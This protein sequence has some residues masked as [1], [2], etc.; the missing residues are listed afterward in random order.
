M[1]AKYGYIGRMLF[2]NLSD[3]T[4]RTEDLSE[5]LAKAFIGGYGIGSRIIYDR[6]KA[7]MDP[8]GPENIFG[9]GTGPLHLPEPFPPVASPQWASLP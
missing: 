4:T 3:G 5:D 9:L 1:I 8:L 7:G 2:V 6:M